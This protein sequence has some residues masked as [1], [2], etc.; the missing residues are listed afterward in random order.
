MHVVQNQMIKYFLCS[1]END[2]RMMELNPVHVMPILP[3]GLV[4]S[5]AEQDPSIKLSEY[6]ISKS[7]NDCDCETITY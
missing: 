4:K 3:Y 2:L 7:I 6:K 5:S 1:E